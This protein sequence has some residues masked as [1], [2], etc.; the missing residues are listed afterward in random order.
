MGFRVKDLG[1]G[2]KDSGFTVKGERFRQTVQIP[3]MPFKEI[4]WFKIS[5]AGVDRIQ[6]TEVKSL[7][8]GASKTRGPDD[9][10][11][12]ALILAFEDSTYVGAVLGLRLT[13]IS[14]F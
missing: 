11:S 14:T 6:Y 5:Y 1:F 13:P 2:V 4:Q 9:K 7:G 8:I 10:I 12:I 3:S